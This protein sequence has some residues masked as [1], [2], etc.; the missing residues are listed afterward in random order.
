MNSLMHKVTALLWL[1]LFLFFATFVLSKQAHADSVWLKPLLN[2]EKITIAVTDSG[3][4]GLSVVAD[5]V[6][7]FEKHH[8]FKNVEL[9]FFNALFTNAGGYNS[10]KTRDD[11]LKVFSSA[12]QSLQ[13]NYAPD[14][15]LIACNTLSVI[16]EDTEFARTTT[17]PVVGIVEDGVTQI[18]EKIG[19]NPTAKNIIFAT[20]TTISENSHKSSLVARGVAADQIITQ[21]CPELTLYIEQGF[22][23]METELLIDAYVDEAVSQLDEKIDPLYVSFNCTHFGYSLDLWKQAFEARGVA[24][25][26]FLNPNTKMINFLLPEEKKERFNQTEI[27]VRVIS[28]TDIPADRQASIGRYLQTISSFA[29]DALV[30]F[31]LKP[32][33][34]EWR[35]LVNN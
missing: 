29:A 24:V 22:D 26:G 12:L 19:Q 15:I 18:N 17:T 34:F 35:N 7:K 30:N 11:K 32:A 8:G 23:S 3:L 13:D 28:M 2:K 5:A 25:E 33:L 10:L 9:I 6:Q 16:Y 14:V 21:A 1:A 27:I 4:G 20:Q 31:E